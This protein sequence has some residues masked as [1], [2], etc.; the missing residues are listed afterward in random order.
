MNC[1]TAGDSSPSVS[2]WIVIN[3]KAFRIWHERLFQLLRIDGTYF[4]Q[5]INRVYAKKTT[6][7]NVCYLLFTYW[8]TRSAN[9]T[10]NKHIILGNHNSERRR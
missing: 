9:R 2:Y 1:F 8:Y 5:N 10:E 6:H 3:I 7:T 4:H